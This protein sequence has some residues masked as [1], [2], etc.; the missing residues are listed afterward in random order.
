MNTAATSNS[1]S[2]TSEAAAAQKDFM[3]MS[4]SAADHAVAIAAA[5][6][7]NMHLMTGSLKA[8]NNNNDLNLQSPFFAPS[9]GNP[10]MDSFFM[11]Q[12]QQQL[13]QAQLFSAAAAANA[14]SPNSN[15]MMTNLM[16]D[17]SALTF[18]P[19][20][21]F[22]DPSTSALF[23][24]AISPNNATTATNN[25]NNSGNALGPLTPTELF[26]HLNTL[27]GEE[28]SN[29]NNNHATLD[30]SAMMAEDFQLQQQRQQHQQQGFSTFAD[31][32]RHFKDL[33]GQF[34]LQQH[35]QDH[36]HQPTTPSV[37]LSS[38]MLLANAAGAHH[39]GFSSPL[40][41]PQQTP[42]QQHLYADSFSLRSGRTP[43]LHSEVSNNWNTLNLSFG[44][45]KTD[46]LIYVLRHVVFFSTSLWV[47]PHP[48]PST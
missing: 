46:L 17:L 25:N 48:L 32:E 15:S 40:S 31:L 11:Q 39:V 27:K 35:Q 30:F 44:L 21:S 41:Q 5:G 20:I 19:S 9:S 3:S 36:H 2:M 6:L 7:P 22:T 18:D 33:E 1:A 13:H 24:M 4:I 45:E 38:D 34:N 16:A 14:V 26:Q 42:P 10:L 23:G 28:Q 8:H 37:V 12:Q 43:S 47:Q 29:S